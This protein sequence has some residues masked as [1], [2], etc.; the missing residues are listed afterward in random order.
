MHLAGDKVCL[1]GGGDTFR[2]LHN[3]PTNVINSESQEIG[4]PLGEGLSLVRQEVLGTWKEETHTN[5]DPFAMFV[6]PCFHYSHFYR[7]PSV[8]FAY[9]GFILLIAALRSSLRKDLFTT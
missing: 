6:E 5:D 4:K 2:S 8:G 7:Y 9:P 3:R 1:P